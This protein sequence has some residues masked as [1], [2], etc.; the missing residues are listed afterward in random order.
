MKAVH[1]GPA[2]A[3]AFIM[4]SLC[5]ANCVPMEGDRGKE[6]GQ[7]RGWGDITRCLKIC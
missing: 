2:E 6:E 3:D 4:R 1:A 7:G 5:R